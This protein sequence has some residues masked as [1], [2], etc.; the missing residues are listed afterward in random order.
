MR[1]SERQLDNDE[2][3]NILDNGE[4]GILATTGENKYS[5]AVPLNYI[6]LDNTI[7]FHCALEGNK[8]EN[9]S[10]NNKVCFCVV[11][12]AD[13]ISSKF[14]TKY[15]S[16]IAFGQASTVSDEDER[17]KVLYGFIQ[18]FSPDFKK[19]GSIYIDK[20]ISKTNIIKI[21]IDHVTAKGRLK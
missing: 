10:Y 14:T 8:I 18:K 19:E 1:K 15:K 20:A 3:K 21:S 6:Y 4:Y 7:Y 2:I 11:R 17:R 5:Y 13:V 16:A 12:K 9:I